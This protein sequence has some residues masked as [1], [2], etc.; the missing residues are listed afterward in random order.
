MSALLMEKTEVARDVK[1]IVAEMASKARA[2]M[3]K[4]Q[5]YN[6]A[7][8][9]ELVQA[10]AWAIYNS[11]H[12]AEL[13]EMAVRETG[14]GKYEDKITKN[15]R[16]TLGT[17][18]DLL[19]P[20]AK[21]AGVISVDE[22]KGLIEIAKP[23]GLVGAAAPTTNPA[24]TPA[25]VVMMALKGRNAILIAPS[26][27]GSACALKLLEYIHAELAKIGAP[28]DLVQVLPPPAN[29][30]L[31]FEMMRC[32]DLVT[33]TGSAANVKAGQTCGK[34]NV[35][36]SEGNVVSVIESTANLPEAA[37]LIAASKTFDHGTSCS[38]ENHLVSEASVYEPMLAELKKQGGY[39]CTCTEK[40]ALHSAMWDETGKR[41]ADTTAKPAAVITQAAGLNSEEAKTA[42]FIMV[43]ETGIGKEYLF[44]GEK[45]SI[46]AAVYKVQDF[47]EAIAVTKRILNHQGKGHS[48]GLHTTNESHMLRIGME[49]PVCRL[50]INQAQCFGNGGSFNNGLGFTLSMGGGTW[51]GNNIGEN[52]SYKHFINITK[53]AKVIPEIVPTEEELFGSYWSKYGR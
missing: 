41:K 42:K 53:V 19:S 50:L 22:E 5:D 51:A 36:V 32:A 52:L 2:A 45:L 16:K 48:C 29:K 6:Q 20:D 14:L 33:V 3:A 49:M 30:E 1:K 28:L 11:D 34:P 27:K 39:M 25:N 44:S 35:C 40:T 47:E 8:T 37:R 13:A 17:L 24:A 18:R 4:I 31:T 9:N 15:K 12:A 38:S 10:V 7:Q 46:V 26:P 21:S 43:E 23:V